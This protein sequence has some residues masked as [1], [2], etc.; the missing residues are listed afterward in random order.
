MMKTGLAILLLTA[1]IAC[2]CAVPLHQINGD[3]ATGNV[4]IKCVP[5]N[6]KVYLD[7]QYV[8][9]ASLFDGD[10]KPLKVTV[11]A[12]VVQFE[13]DEYQVERRDIVTSEGGQELT[14][15]M[16]LRPIAPEEDEK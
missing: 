13:L 11:G 2:G 16:R 9:K 12:H 6:A 8:G 4:V 15:Q 3:A 7:G 10:K 1:L 5:D 14:I